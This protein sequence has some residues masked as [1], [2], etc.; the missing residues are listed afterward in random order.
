M[1]GVC[2][3][4]SNGFLHSRNAIIE[5]FEGAIA[6]GLDIRCLTELL[7]EQDFLPIFQ[8]GTQDA[9][10]KGRIAVRNINS[11][12]FCAFTDRTDAIRSIHVSFAF[13]FFR[14][15]SN[16]SMRGRNLLTHSMS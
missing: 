4:D 11:Q 16:L 5:R 2:Y 14:T 3:T 12:P 9:F 15:Q 1:K 8:T 13:V 10:P 7:L 6:K